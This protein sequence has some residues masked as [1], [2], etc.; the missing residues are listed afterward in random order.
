MGLL[1]GLTTAEPDLALDQ[2]TL[3]VWSGGLDV[4]AKALEA[5]AFVLSADEKARADRFRFD[6]DRT[7]FVVTRGVLRFFLGAY[8]H[9]LPKDVAFCY[10]PK[11]KPELANKGTGVCF[12]VSHSHGMGMWAFAINRPV[13]VDVEYV[14]RS[15]NIDAVG[16]RF[17]SDDEWRHLCDLPDDQRRKSFFRC[18]TRKEA[19]VKAIGDGL[20]FSLKA[21][22]VSVGEMAQLKRIDG[23]Y[24][25]Q[26]WTLKAIEPTPEYVGAVAFEGQARVLFHALLPDVGQV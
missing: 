5:Y 6:K 21:F 16:K 18:W 8:T 11:G 10:G 19:F 3:H 13:G 7:H 1:P 15:V 12:N 9:R 22:D 2:D 4:D 20:S 26:K 24:D 23:E 17:F 14:E 25:P